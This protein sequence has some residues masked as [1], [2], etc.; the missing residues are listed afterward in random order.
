MA[1]S[2]G[3]ERDK[4]VVEKDESTTMT[5]DEAVAEIRRQNEEAIQEGLR[6]MREL[7]KQDRTLH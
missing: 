2:K 3:I 4:P 5:L 6:K 1:R 7:L